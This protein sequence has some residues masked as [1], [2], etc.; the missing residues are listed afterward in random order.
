[1]DAVEKKIKVLSESMITHF[2]VQ[3]EDQYFVSYLSDN[4]LWMSDDNTFYDRQTT[5]AYLKQLRD[6]CHGV[7]KIK[8]QD[9]HVYSLRPHICFVVGTVTIEVGS[10]ENQFRENEICISGIWQEESNW[11]LTHFYSAIKD[12][13]LMSQNGSL[14]LHQQLEVIQKATMIDPLTQINNLQ[15]FE[16]EAAALLKQYP[17][18]KYVMIKFGIRDFR[19]VNRR[20]GYK[21][22][23]LVLKHIA[24]NLL[25]TLNDRETCGRMEKDVFAMLY[26]FEDKAS[27]EQRVEQLETVLIDTPLR[28]RLETKI[29]FNIGIYQI[30]NDHTE[31]IKDMLDKALIAQ[32]KGSTSI[33]HRHHYAYYEE[34][35][36]TAQYQRSKL[37]EE[38]P[39]AMEENEFSLY[40]QPQFDLTSG[41][42]VAGEALVRWITQ[43][44]IR[45]P[46]EFIPIFEE[47]GFIFSFDYYML[48]KICQQMRKW[49]DVGVEVHPISTNQSRLH[50]EEENYFKDFCAVIDRYQIPHEYIIFEL[51][52]SAFV[53]NS[54]KMVR[55]TELLHEHHYK[56]A[57]DDFGTGYASL[58]LLSVVPADI[59]KIDKSMLKGYSTNIRT[60]IIIERIIQL[61]HDIGMSV[62]C[63]GIEEQAEWEYLKKIGCNIG[64]GFLMGKPV[65]AEAYRKLW[66]K[67]PNR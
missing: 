16:K 67:T 40:I 8:H 20:H 58:N 50:I 13:R 33:S 12:E 60:Q 66:L 47:Q 15:G 52:E 61:A 54:E 34:W 44:G 65:E 63:E 38:A 6:D 46:G 31:Y 49:I 14:S 64:Q 22:G 57:I 21:M 41:T 24:K 51:T 17:K 23:D 55:L 18:Q 26:C 5:L 28:Q 59:L 35:M 45:M 1:M 43:D 19:F 27:L 29:H 4:L 48:D 30:E 9:F 2:F 37:L 56:I 11:C 32:K 7:V 25:A 36:M 10:E 42:L 62:V 39:K 3:K 53:E